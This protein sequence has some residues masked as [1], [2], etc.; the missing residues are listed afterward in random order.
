MGGR[1][2]GVGCPGKA[3]AN[4]GVFLKKFLSRLG[5]GEFTVTAS[6][7]PKSVAGGLS[8]DLKEGVT[9]RVRPP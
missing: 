5:P 4:L 7:G 8:L 3:F 1:S 9:Y 2:Q 6:W